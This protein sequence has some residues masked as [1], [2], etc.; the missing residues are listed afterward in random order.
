ML[1]KISYAVPA[2]GTVKIYTLYIGPELM[3]LKNHG[4]DLEEMV[5]KR[6]IDE[7]SSRR[8]GLTLEQR[9]EYEMSLDLMGWTFV[10]AGYDGGEWVPLGGEDLGRSRILW[11]INNCEKAF[12]CPSPGHYWFEDATEASFFKLQCVKSAVVAI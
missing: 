1:D 6:I 2:A 12:T 5:I 8:K 11:M 3:Y 9:Q 7:M 10:S 4:P